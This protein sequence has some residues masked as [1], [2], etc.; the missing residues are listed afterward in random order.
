MENQKSTLPLQNSLNQQLMEITTHPIKTLLSLFSALV[1]ALSVHSQNHHEYKLLW[2]ISGKG[3]QSPSYLFGSAHVK[4]SRAFQFS[5]SVML[6]LDACTLFALEVH[7]DSAAKHAFSYRKQAKLHTEKPHLTAAQQTEVMGRYES[8][9]GHVPDSSILAN[10]FL[11]EQLMSALP[12]KPDDRVSVVDA[13]LWGIAQTLHKTPR[14]LEQ[15][16]DLSMKLNESKSISGLFTKDQSVYRSIAEQLISLYSVGNLDKLWELYQINAEADTTLVR[17]NREMANSII[18]LTAEGSLFAVVG[19]AHLPG[20]NGII[21]L[22]KAAGYTVSPVEATFTGVADKYTI[23]GSKMQWQALKDSINHFQ[24]DL[25]VGYS[26]TARVGRAVEIRQFD[27]ANEAELLVVARP[28]GPPGSVDP[29]EQLEQELNL[30]LAV[31]NVSMQERRF[32]TAHG[33]PALEM[34]MRVGRNHERTQVLLRDNVQYTLTVLHTSEKTDPVLASRFFESFTLLPITARN[35]QPYVFRHVAGAFEVQFPFAPEEQL[36]AVEDPGLPDYEPQKIHLFSV[37]DQANDVAYFV[38][39]NDFPPGLFLTNKTET[40]NM[41]I[42]HLAANAE[43]IHAPASWSRAG[44][45]GKAATIKNKDGVLVAVEVFTRGNRLYLLMKNSG[46]GA[47]SNQGNDFF[48][49]FNVLPIEPVSYS[50]FSLGTLATEIPGEPVIQEPDPE[51]IGGDISVAETAFSVDPHSGT[52]YGIETMTFS[53]YTKIDT[54]NFYQRI[55]EGMRQPGDSLVA[56]IDITVEEQAGKEFQIIRNTSDIANRIRMWIHGDSFHILQRLGNTEQLHGPATD[57]FFSQV[58]STPANPDFDIRSSKAQAIM[59]DLRSTDTILRAAARE[60]LHVSYQFDS[61]EIAFLREALHHVYADEDS[62]Y[63]NTKQQLIRELASLRDR[64]SVLVLKRLFDNEHESDLVK[65]AVLTQITTLDSSTF[66]WY[67]DALVNRTPVIPQGGYELFHPLYD[68][69]AHVATHLHQLM[70]L[71]AIDDYRPSVLSISSLVSNMDTPVAQQAIRGTKDVL[72]QYAMADLGTFLHLLEQPDDYPSYGTIY[73]YLTILPALDTAALVQA[74]TEPLL[75][76]GDDQFEMQ[77]SAAAARIRAGIAVDDALLHARLADLRTRRELLEA[78]HRAGQLD[79]V[80]TAFLT[81][82]ALATV[83]LYHHVADFDEYPEHISLLGQLM[84]EGAQYHVFEFTW[85][86][87]E[88]D[89]THY[90]GISKTIAPNF[91]GDGLFSW[92]P[93]FTDYEPVE[94]GSAWQDHAEQLIEQ[95]RDQE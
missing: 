75:Q 78:Y 34:V 89:T 64:E 48:G 28:L 11:I 33:L 73:H 93:S 1:I 3:L 47:Q 56:D 67:F 41:M 51:D 95:L 17:R 72:T 29:S 76:L 5:D 66:T 12:V 90:I 52:L 25:P 32:F 21:S 79:R 15:V 27:I 69:L 55:M 7:P 54:S 65:A 70:P 4:D 91:T 44:L 38:R 80:P 18:E 2:K 40:L 83:S 62:V 26:E 59:R 45:N 24:V 22:L 53:P 74:F 84:H 61:T 10:P 88:G 71:L 30:R 92:Y 16:S 77:V 14:G 50:P 57:R 9:Y 6:S 68:S 42:Q 87:Y 63:P 19:V 37:L 49:S 46:P 94:E 81:P 36:I 60:A 43:F 31:K 13:Y 86:D 82:E 8:S 58:R 85:E 20:N 35:E 39:Y 23:D